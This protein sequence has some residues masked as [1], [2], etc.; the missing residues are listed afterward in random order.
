M[1]S[2]AVPKLKQAILEALQEAEDLADVVVSADKEPE[3]AKEYV[4]IYKGKAKRDFKLLRPPPS[5]LEEEARVFLRVLVIKGSKDP[6]PSAERAVEIADAV[7]ETLRALELGAP[8]LSSILIEER[9]EEPLL[10]DKSRGCH[11]LMTAL[12]KARV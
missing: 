8:F 6:G 9:E 3:R 11:V 10:F 1:P 7:E 12:A 4:W 5:P 2:T